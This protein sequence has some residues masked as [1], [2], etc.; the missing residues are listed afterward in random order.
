MFHNRE[1]SALRTDLD[2]EYE[3]DD[4]QMGGWDHE[5]VRVLF[6]QLEFRTLYP[7]LLEAIGEEAEAAPKG[8]TLDATVRTL[9]SADEIVE[10][11]H[12][13]AAHGGRYAIEPRWDSTA[14]G[15]ALAGLAF[16]DVNDE[17]VYIH[18]DHL[19]D[20][21]VQEALVEMFGPKG[22]PLV[23]HRAKE[24]MHG[25]QRAFDVDVRS[26]DLDTALMA[27]LLDPGEGKYDLEQLALRFLALELASPDREEGTL[28]LDGD[29]GPEEIRSAGHHRPA[30]G[31]GAGRRAAEAGAPAAVRAGRA[32]TRERP[33]PDGGRRGQD[34]PR[35]P[36]GAARGPA[37]RSA[38]TSRRRSTPTRASRSS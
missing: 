36:R 2:L 15:A 33:G 6:E 22:P 10:H 14:A 13:V 38:T 20:A 29:A 24:L 1:M 26:L 27:Y 12:E 9:R 28:D 32:P 31:R 4:L 16:A 17:A 18:V 37:D 5:A 7:R 21:A 3:P 25:L 30:A 23:A 19:G 11:L 35:V 8:Q 34:R